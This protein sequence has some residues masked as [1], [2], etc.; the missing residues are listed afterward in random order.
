MKWQ[1]RRQSANVE[2]RRGSGGGGGGLGDLFGRRSPGGSG[3]PMGGGGRGGGMSL[4]TIVI[5]GAIA[6]FIFGVNPLNLLGSMMGGGTGMGAPGGGAIERSGPVSAEQ[7]TQAAFAKTVFAM[8]ED[9]WTEV[10]RQSGRRYQEPTL[11]LFTGQTQTACGVGQ[12]AMGPFFCPGDQKVY[13]DLDFFAELATRFQAAGDFAQ[14]YV[15]AHEVGHHIQTLLGISAE[16]QR[17]RQSVGEAEGNDLSVRQELQADCLAGVWASY[18]QTELKVLEPGDIDE[19]LRAAAAV[20][21]DTIQKRTRG[22]A[23]QESFTHGSAEQRQRWFRTGFQSG[24][25]NA[26]DTFAAGAL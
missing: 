21:D 4:W 23:V 5:I 25:I 13:I 8:T 20:G 24:A 22:Y 16:V 6:W 3:I 14:A 1:G 2:D 19:A 15:I 12:A 17:R 11:V 7:E 26:C 10:F 9:V 18:A